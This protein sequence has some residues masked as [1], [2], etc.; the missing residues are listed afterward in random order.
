M[1]FQRLDGAL[2]GF[3]LSVFT[4]A[5]L[6]T[7]TRVFYIGGIGDDSVGF[8]D[9]GTTEGGGGT[10]RLRVTSTGSVLIGRDTGLTGAGQLDVNSSIRAANN[11]TLSSTGISVVAGNLSMPNGSSITASGGTLTIGTVNAAQLTSS[12][13]GQI[14]GILSV[15]DYIQGE[16]N[17]PVKFNRGINVWGIS[18]PWGYR[19]SVSGSR[20]GNIALAQLLSTL[21]TYGLIIDNTTA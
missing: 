2:P 17:G 21:A 13:N 19:P 12:G 20:A 5:N 4:L 18:A 7:P 15:N 1:L 10:V 6:D 11:V 8:R 3:F 16:S 9:H 14:V